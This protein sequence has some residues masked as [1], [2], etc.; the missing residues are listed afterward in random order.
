MLALHQGGV[1]P[2]SS[3]LPPMTMKSRSRSELSKKLEQLKNQNPITPTV[4]YRIIIIHSY[5]AIQCYTV[6]NG[7]LW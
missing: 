7:W 3:V 1:P 5:I 4:L 6:K 2:Q